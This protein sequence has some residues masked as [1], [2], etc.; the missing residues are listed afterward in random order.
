MQNSVSRDREKYLGGSDIPALLGISRYK[1]RWQLLREKTGLEPVQE[2]FA[3]KYIT[4]G[5]TMEPKIRDYLNTGRAP[6]CEYREAKFYADIPDTHLQKRG[7]LD[8]YDAHNRFVLEIKTTDRERMSNVRDY[9]DYLAQMLFYMT[10]TDEPLRGGVLAIYF[11][12]DDLNEVF[13]ET[14]LQIFKFTVEEMADDIADLNNEIQM[15]VADMQII[16]Q[17]PE[18]SEAELLD[19]ELADVSKKAVA[20][21][22]AIAAFKETEKKYAEVKG[23]LVEL[24]NKYNV[25][26]FDAGGYQVALVKGCPEEIT[27]K[28]ECDMDAL[29]TLF[30]EAYDECVKTVEKKKAGR[31]DFVKITAKKGAGS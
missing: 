13:D 15:F 28:E 30:P 25:K 22:Q 2:V 31:K 7:H 6:E 23:R 9:P 26:S 17:N 8:G 29:A 16:E 27:T 20:F 12:P 3:N 24:M 5:N 14:R 18:K 1:T 11:R 10:I 19:K 4:Y 21:E